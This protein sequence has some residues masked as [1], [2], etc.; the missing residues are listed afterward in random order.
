[1]FL[2]CPRTILCSLAAK[3]L[4]GAVPGSL[5]DIVFIADVILVPLETQIKFC[6]SWNMTSAKEKILA[7][8]HQFICDQTYISYTCNSNRYITVYEEKT[9]YF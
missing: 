4:V 9:H 6:F 1:M 3:S 2:P 5:T 7:P 8:V